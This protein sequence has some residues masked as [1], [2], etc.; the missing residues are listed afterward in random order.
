MP[1]SDNASAY[2]LR[3][4]G[5]DDTAPLVTPLTPSYGSTVRSPT[6]PSPRT[7]ILN[8]TLK[9]AA[10]FVVGTAALGM[11]LWLALPPLDEY[12][13]LWSITIA[14]LSCAESIDRCCASQ[15]RLTSSRSSTIY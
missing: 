12:V 7:T 5:V 4:V 11:T 14:Y 3:L 1:L 15:S 9:M 2:S 13:S 8:A 6:R 10:L